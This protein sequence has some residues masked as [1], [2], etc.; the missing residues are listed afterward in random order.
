MTN[1]LNYYVFRYVNWLPP[2]F[3]A[4]LRV[5]WYGGSGNTACLSENNPKYM[6]T[7][8]DIKSYLQV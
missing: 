2:V 6:V 5:Y 4:H 1:D 3:I 7:I 8:E